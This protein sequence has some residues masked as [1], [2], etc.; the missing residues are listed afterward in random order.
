MRIICRV[1]FSG[2]IA[3]QTILSHYFSLTI[4]ITRY[5][6]RIKNKN[7]NL[8]KDIV[9]NVTSKFLLEYSS[10]DVGFCYNG[11]IIL[12]FS[13]PYFFFPPAQKKINSLSVIKIG[14]AHK[15][16]RAIRTRNESPPLVRPRVI[17]ISRIIQYT[18]TAI[19]ITET[20]GKHVR[21][22]SVETIYRIEPFVR[23]VTGRTQF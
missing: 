6:R 21:T 1:V 18:R 7:N 20:I 16:K 13:C 19:D 15:T 12:S 5:S 2:Y 3:K 9:L 23:G 22:I 14:R 8:R 17:I 4:V 10:R 11:K